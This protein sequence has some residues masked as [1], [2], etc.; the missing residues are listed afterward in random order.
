MQTKKNT[1]N[2]SS[3]EINIVDFILNNNKF[4]AILSW[5]LSFMDLSFHWGGERQRQNTRT[6]LGHGKC[7]EKKKQSHSQR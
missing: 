2:K 4:D 3:R 7:Y 6:I 5:F 1:P